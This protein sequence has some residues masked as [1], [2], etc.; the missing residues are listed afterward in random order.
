MEHNIIMSFFKLVAYY[1]LSPNDSV[2]GGMIIGMGMLFVGG[3]HS[4]F[5]IGEF[6][7]GTEKFKKHT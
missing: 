4:M 1:W 2:G 5:E 3:P 6:L 7:A